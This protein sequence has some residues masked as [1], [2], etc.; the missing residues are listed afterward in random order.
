MGKDDIEIGLFGF[1][2]M[3]FTVTNEDILFSFQQRVLVSKSAPAA[4][5][6]HNYCS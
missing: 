3:H 6:L 4:S 2:H 1:Y 5:V